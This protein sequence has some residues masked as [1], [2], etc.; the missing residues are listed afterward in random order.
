MLMTLG[1]VALALCGVWMGLKK[2]GKE[3]VNNLALLAVQ[4]RPITIVFDADL[5]FK[6]AYNKRSRHW[7]QF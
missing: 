3:L 1:F 6:L 2:G 5:A 7:Q 4:G